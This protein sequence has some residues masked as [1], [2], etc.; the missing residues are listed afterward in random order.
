MGTEASSLG[1][2]TVPNIPVISLGLSLGA[3][4]AISL[5]ACLILG[6]VV[7][8]QGMHRPW[9]Q[10][11][12]G[13]SWTLRGVAIALVWTQVY[14]W[15]VALAFGNL[16]NVVAARCGLDDGKNATRALENREKSKTSSNISTPR[17]TP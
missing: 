7:P 15:W 8:N 14:A 3:F 17:R 13:F 11:F 5:V 12:P 4:F 2:R 10:F 1:G 6:L 9:L 16:F